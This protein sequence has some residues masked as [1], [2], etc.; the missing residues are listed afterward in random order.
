MPETAT[1]VPSATTYARSLAGHGF[2]IGIVALAI[3]RTTGI[4]F[5][6]HRAHNWRDHCWRGIGRATN[7]F[8]CV[9]SGA[10]SRHEPK[11]GQG[12]GQ[13]SIEG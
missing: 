11:R 5:W 2:N 12:D 4:I 8:W 10:R 13:M 9:C 3:E 6:E 1:I 7:K